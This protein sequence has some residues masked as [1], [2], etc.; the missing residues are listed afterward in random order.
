M[1]TLTVE[2]VDGRVISV[3]LAW[4]SRLWSGV[5][6]ERAHFEIIRDGTIIHWPDLDEDLSVNGILAGRR[7]GESPE[8]LKKWLAARG[9]WEDS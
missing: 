3:P 8:S 9:K 4:Y 1:E 7:F 2:L 5:P 6:E